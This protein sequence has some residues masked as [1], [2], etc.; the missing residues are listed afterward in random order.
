MCSSTSASSDDVVDGDR[1]NCRDHFKIIDKYLIEYELKEV[2]NPDDTTKTIKQGYIVF[3]DHQ[4]DCDWKDE[5]DHDTIFEEDGRVKFEQA[6]CK[7]NIAHAQPCNNLPEEEVLIFKKMIGAGYALALNGDFDSIDPLIKSATDYLCLRNK[8][9]A[10]RY[11]L[12]ASGGVA[13]IV[14]VFWLIAKFWLKLGYQDWIAGICMGI[15]GSFVSVWTRY[16]RMSLTGL[17]SQFLHYLEA[18]SRMFVGSVFALVVLFAINCH[19]V[20]P[21]LNAN[22]HI[23]AFALAG[24]LAG[25]SERFVPSLMERLSNEKTESNE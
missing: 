17:S 10:R 8:E 24:F 15:L 19:I 5:R 9:M 1:Q 7:L 21:E 23:P 14:I 22:Y 20:F 2:P 6:I 3:I 25:F 13:V 12:L 4:N 18:I 11:F 16:G